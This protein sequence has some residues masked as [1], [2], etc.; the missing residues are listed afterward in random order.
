[1]ASLSQT[2]LLRIAAFLVDGLSF[3]L[4]LMVPASF[5]SYGIVW[6]GAWMK[7]IPMIWWTTMLIVFVA[8]LFRDGYRGRSPGKRLLGL[9]VQTRNGKPC[10][11]F[12]SL[13]RNLT[14]LIPLWNVL[15]IYLVLF[16][17]EGRR[18]GDR[19]AGTVVVEE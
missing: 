17:R 1:M 16:G 15:E 19:F 5:L 6:L 7:A 13:K 3:A 2:T 14:L 12:C 9:R 10:S 4:V 8:M 18:T 11:Y